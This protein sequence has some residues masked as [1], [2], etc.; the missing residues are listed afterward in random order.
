MQTAPS[1]VSAGDEWIGMTRERRRPR[2]IGQALGKKIRLPRSSQLDA[3]TAGNF[4][5]GS[6]Y[7]AGRTHQLEQAG[8]AHCCRVPLPE[9]NSH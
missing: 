4:A 7:Y 3:V 2:P 9:V 8:N 1:R 5:R 6:T